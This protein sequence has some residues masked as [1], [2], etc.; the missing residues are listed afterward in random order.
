MK[1]NLNIIYVYPPSSIISYHSLNL[2]VFWIN[3]MLKPGLPPQ[4]PQKK[5]NLWSI[6]LYPP[7]NRGERFEGNLYNIHL[8]TLQH[9]ILQLFVL[10]DIFLGF[11]STQK[12]LPPTLRRSEGRA[13]S[14]TCEVQH[15]GFPS[16][17]LHCTHHRK[18][19]WQ[20][21][22]GGYFFKWLFFHCHISFQ[23]C[24]PF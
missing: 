21:L 5:H 22:I 9:Y 20:F 13:E 10:V 15:G 12:I 1:N 19:I 6:N 3:I 14:T 2:F 4:H 18:L 23:G 11:L 16:L 7:K 8:T 17:P 24:I